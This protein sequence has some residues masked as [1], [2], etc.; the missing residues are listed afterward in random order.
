MAG[1]PMDRRSFLGKL[2]LVAGAAA[3][4]GALLASGCAGATFVVP[5]EFGPSLAVPASTVRPEGVFVAH[6]RDQRPIF[7][8]RSGDGTFTAVHARC[9]HRGCQPDIVAGRLVCPCHGSEFA[10][11]GAVLEGPAGEPLLRYE[12]TEND[13]TV[14][15]HVGGGQV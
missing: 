4:G 13:G 1:G 5:R 6:P 2:P 8:T 9:T 10:A 14:L 12:V 15:I 11:D 3:G 7:L